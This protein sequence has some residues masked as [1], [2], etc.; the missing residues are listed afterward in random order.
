MSDEKLTKSGL[1]MAIQT[2]RTRFENALAHFSDIQKSEILL[3]NG[4]SIKDVMVHI[5]SWERIG[6]EIV[7]SAQ[8]GKSLKPYIAKVFESVDKF[9]AQTYENNKDKS[10][11]RIEAEYQTAYQIFLALIESLDK[12]FIFSNLPFEGADEISVQSIISANTHLHYKE[13]AEAIEKIIE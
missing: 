5:A 8:D 4:W 6:F 7:Q 12:S 3:E 13:H 9:N 1:L 2:N 11:T 10:L